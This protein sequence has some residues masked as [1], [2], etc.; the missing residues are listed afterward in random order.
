MNMDS[1]QR[2]SSNTDTSKEQFSSADDKGD[3]LRHAGQGPESS[4]MPP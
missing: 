4:Q 2:S 1:G 3:E